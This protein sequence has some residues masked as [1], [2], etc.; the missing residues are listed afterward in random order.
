MRG[1]A[2]QAARQAT[3]S[4]AHFLTETD[5]VTG[6]RTWC[7]AWTFAD[8]PL[9]LGERLAP[10]E[11]TEIPQY[12]SG[13]SMLS[14]AL[15]EVRMASQRCL[16]RALFESKNRRDFQLRVTSVVIGD[17]DSTEDWGL[18]AESLAR[19]SRISLVST[20]PGASTMLDRTARVSVHT[21]IDASSLNE[22]VLQRMLSA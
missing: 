11:L 19:I 14:R 5:R 2:L 17:F 4:I 21:S 3:L 16:E 20:C 9:L 13:A 6:D 18:E 15:R 22:T 8:E 12:G 1:A 7:S 10:E